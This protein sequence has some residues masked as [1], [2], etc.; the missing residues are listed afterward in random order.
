MDGD[1]AC[2]TSQHN[3]PASLPPRLFV[4]CEPSPAAGIDA[5]LPPANH[6]CHARPAGQ[7][8]VAS[9]VPKQRN[10]SRKPQHRGE[11][12]AED[13]RRNQIYTA[14]S[15]RLILQGPQN[16]IGPFA[17][18]AAS[19]QQPASSPAAFAPII[20]RSRVACLT[21]H[22]P[23]QTPRP[24]S[25]PS[26]RGQLPPTM[27]SLWPISQPRASPSDPFPFPLCEAHISAM[28]AAWLLRLLGC[29]SRCHRGSRS[30]AI[31][32]MCY[33]ALSHPGSDKHSCPPREPTAV[34]QACFKFAGDAPRGWGMSPSC[35]AGP[36]GHQEMTLSTRTHDATLGLYTTRAANLCPQ[37]F[38]ACA[39]HTA[40]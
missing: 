38:R 40:S 15:Y 39:G 24:A 21:V 3:P 7:N 32:P 8:S 5:A 6:G 10:K 9:A 1:T 20:Q 16:P 29:S 4:G 27:L 11:G 22:Q 28:A 31:S 26:P 37:S 36:D 33:R 17:P 14:A 13:A 2:N 25:P 30:T 34:G 18:P 23:N 12:V 19:S 35:F